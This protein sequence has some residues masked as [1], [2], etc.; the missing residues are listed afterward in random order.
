VADTAQHLA[1]VLERLLYLAKLRDTA[2][3]RYT[4]GELT[5]RIRASLVARS[6]SDA[7]DVE[8]SPWFR[9]D[10][11]SALRSAGWRSV[12]TDNVRYWKGIRA[13]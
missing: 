4:A 9:A 1:A 10:L 3:E 7:L 2:L 8:D 12:R 6:V 13:R 11:T 5:A